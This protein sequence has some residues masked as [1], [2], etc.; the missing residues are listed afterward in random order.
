[1]SRQVII[2]TRNKDKARELQTLLLNEGI[3]VQTLDDVDPEHKI[4]EIK[5]TGTTLEENALLKA[6]TVAA[7]LGR[8]AIADDT[9]LEV[10]ALD[11]APGVYAARYAGEGCS[12]ED[13]VNKLLAELVNVP[14]S[15]RTARFRTIACFA[16]GEKELT[17]EGVVE[18]IITETPR[19]ED[20]F[21][22]DPVFLIFH[23][24]KTYAQLTKEEKNSLSHR[25]RAIK[26]LISLLRKRQILKSPSPGDSSSIQGK[27]RGAS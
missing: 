10:D 22:Y 13:N 7:L 18:G 27:N 14:F 11:S 16:D 24:G 21:G 6:R 9:G 15:D 8:P 23:L 19:G 2:A 26:S 5:E 25:S 4:P 1:M 3:S 20:G 12:Y 17:S